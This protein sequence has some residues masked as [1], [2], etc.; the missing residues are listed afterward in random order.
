VQGITKSPP[1]RLRRFG[2]AAFA[3]IMS[4]GWWT[5]RG[6]NSRPP[7]CEW[8]LGSSDGHTP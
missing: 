4:E 6:S 2:V 5:R 7:H 8:V 3:W 1:S